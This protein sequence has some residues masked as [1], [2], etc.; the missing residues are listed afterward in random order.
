[1]QLFIQPDNYGYTG[2]DF[3]LNTFNLNR[4]WSCSLSLQRCSLTVPLHSHSHGLLAEV[5]IGMGTQSS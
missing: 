5:H 2:M 3:T 1:M 4:L